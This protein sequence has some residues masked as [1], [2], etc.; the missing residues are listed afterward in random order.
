[1]GLHKSVLA[2]LSHCH[3]VL[4]LTYVHSYILNMQNVRLFCNVR[5]HTNSTRVLI[6]VPYHVYFVLQQV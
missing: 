5:I 6:E 4:N 1:M 2:S 3:N